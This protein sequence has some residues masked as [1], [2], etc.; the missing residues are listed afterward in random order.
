MNRELERRL[1]RLE[2]E[3]ASGRVRYAVSAAPLSDEERLD[4]YHLPD[5]VEP[6]RDMTDDEWEREN[7]HDRT[8]H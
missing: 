6:L 2:A 3:R 4:G 5:L 8:I 1:R 7:C